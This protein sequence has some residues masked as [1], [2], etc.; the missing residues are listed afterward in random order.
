MNRPLIALMLFAAGTGSVVADDDHE[1][2]RRLLEQGRIVPFE[3]ILEQVRSRHAERLLEVELEEKDQR[4]IY[5]IEIVDPEGVVWE[6]KYD[7]VSGMLIK[8]EKDD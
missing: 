2:V 8:E 7:A 1:R 4:L 6:L 3:Q 5:E